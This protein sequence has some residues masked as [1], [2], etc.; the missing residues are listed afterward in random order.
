M[1]KSI[2]EKRMQKRL[3]EL[4]K[5]WDKFKELTK[6]WNDQLIDSAFD[7]FDSLSTGT[8]V[9][10]GDAKGDA[11]E[12]TFS[13]ET[14]SSSSICAAASEQEQKYKEIV[15]KKMNQSKQVYAVIFDAL[16]SHPIVDATRRSLGPFGP[17]CGL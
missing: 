14:K 8:Q 13:L 15:K 10:K 7:F 11:K 16:P 2:T 12:E 6:Q 1:I 4:D 9:T 3:Y 17:A 5:K